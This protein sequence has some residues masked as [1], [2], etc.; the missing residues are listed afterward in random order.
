MLISA[1]CSVKAAAGTLNNAAYTVCYTPGGDCTDDVVKV[2]GH[3]KSTVYVQA[4][5]FTSAPIVKAIIQAH[6]RGV[7]VLVLLDRSNVSSKYSVVNALKNNNVPFLIDYRP[8]IAHNKVMIID[9]E[10]VVTGSFNF[11]K[12]A[13]MRNAEN[14]LIIDSKA[15]AKN[16][17]QNF[18]KRKSLSESLSKYC[19]SSN[20]CKR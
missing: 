8:A 1:Y 5:S 16:Y 3:A 12:S 4:Y 20:K 17:R 7:T 2:V 19:L 18:D 9:G 14:L 10:I 15:L 13:Q 6:K 11:T